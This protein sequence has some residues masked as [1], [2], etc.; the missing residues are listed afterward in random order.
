[1]KQSKPQ[2]QIRKLILLALL[3][4]PFS[5]IVGQ[6]TNITRLGIVNPTP[7]NISNTLNLVEKQFIKA[8]SLVIVGIYHESQ[9]FSIAAT[10]KFIKEKGY[11][12]ITIEQIKGELTI[13]NLFETNNCT[14]QFQKLFE[15][16]DALIF[17]GG[18]DIPPSIYN[19][20][21]FL[22][23]E[24]IDGGKNWELSFLHHLI[25]G[26]QSKMQPL[27]ASKPNY[28]ILG[29]CLGMQEM[30]VSSGGSLYQDIPFQVYRKTTFESLLQLDA[31]NIHKNY[32]NRIN[33]ENDYSF[34]HFHPILIT[35]KSFLDVQGVNANPVVASVH[36]Q[37]AKAVGK[38]FKVIATSMDGKVVEA[39]QHSV[40]KN[41]Y[42]IQF[43]TEFS[44]L[45]DNEREF[46]VSPTETVVLSEHTR[47]FLKQFWL[48]FSNRL[49]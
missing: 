35:P 39:M 15:N 5:I 20:E 12:H 40:F 8:D 6:S 7:G 16:T 46:V 3:I 28:T 13:Q 34:I 30:N 9:A 36:H 31:A 32:N 49:K 42:G 2:L 37:S 45:Y 14:V 10:D 17:F 41:V 26:S 19:E 24:L 1:M 25:G 21:T 48:N 44:S 29:I 47:T 22:T 38:G 27:L 4:F 18:D 43:H 33:N 11:S 23:T